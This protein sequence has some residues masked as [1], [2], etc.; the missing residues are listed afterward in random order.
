MTHLKLRLKEGD[1]VAERYRIDGVV[2]KGGFGA[3]Y[4]ATD[5]ATGRSVA[6]KVLLANYGSSDTDSKRFRRE[7]ALVKALEH[8]N[9]VAL[10]D[11]GET[12]R[13]IPFIAFELLEG[14][15]LHEVLQR[16]GALGP[17]RARAIAIDVARALSA[18]HE[19]GIIHRDVK[20]QNVFLTSAAPWT[21]VLDFGVAKAP[22]GEGGPS[23]QLTESGQ[24]VGTPQYMA[25]EQV[26]GGE[27]VPATDLY[28]LGLVLAEMLTGT[29]VIADDALL[30]VYLAHIS[31][32]PVRLDARLLESPFA[33][34]LRRATAKSLA[35][36]YP[37]ALAM[38]ADLE[39]VPHDTPWLLAPEKST[40]PMAA[41]V[42][43]PNAVV[44]RGPSSATVV[45]EPEDEPSGQPSSSGAQ[46]MA[47]LS[48]A[49][50]SARSPASHSPFRE[51]VAVAASQ[52]APQG[53]WSAPV[54][55]GH[56][57]L[58]SA[59][60]E[61]AASSARSATTTPMPMVDESPAWRPPVSRVEPTFGTPGTGGAPAPYAAAWGTP[62]TRE[63]TFPYPDGQLPGT[64]L[65]GAVLPGDAPH[66]HAVPT[67]ATPTTANGRPA[68]SGLRAAVVVVFLLVG[69]ALAAG[70][71]LLSQG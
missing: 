4:R 61:P 63:P 18:A 2:G 50:P 46:A 49:T 24:M 21:K 29:R 40:R 44:V 69:L 67:W 53:I 25:P 5:G 41:A 1:V 59:G 55:S 19:R 10:L 28:A 3:V 58:G 23:T 16:E 71:W 34:V 35:E 39:Q 36:R 52:P 33:Q 22:K 31:P 37:S 48:G 17:G 51:L 27:V 57:P 56:V 64:V 42:A 11:Y 20:P 7:A 12:E 9:V 54:S 45:I 68:G 32:E 13:G 65:P 8:P 14:L 30:N 26:R 47:Q 60:R 15:S 38:L 70:A 62:S 6:L 66:P 43:P